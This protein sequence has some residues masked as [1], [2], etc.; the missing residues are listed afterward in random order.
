MGD[1]TAE[2]PRKAMTYRE[3]L[4]RLEADAKAREDGE[5]DMAV[6]LRV[7]DRDGEHHAGNLYDVGVDAGCADDDAL[8]LDAA[9][10]AEPEPEPEIEDEPDDEPRGGITSTLLGCLIAILA[11]LW[12]CT[13][14]AEGIDWLDRRACRDNGG[15][16]EWSGIEWRCT[17]EGRP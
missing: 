10:L 8:V 17:G 1:E 16:V 5:L 6:V 3:L 11:T 4:L 14:I 7:E 2:Q 9:L 13:H 12:V 15:R